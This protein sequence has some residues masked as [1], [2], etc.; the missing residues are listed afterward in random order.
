MS[1]VGFTLV[2]MMVTVAIIG[3]LAAI[4]IPSYQEHVEKTNLA[5]AQSEMSEAAIFFKS[6]MVKKPGYFENDI[7]NRRKA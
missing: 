5:Y 2:E 4:A 1:Y 3:I 6:E 7:K